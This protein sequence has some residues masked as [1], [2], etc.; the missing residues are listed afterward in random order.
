V[1]DEEDFR[2]A[3]ASILKR[4]GYQVDAV[5]DAES[6]LTWLESNRPDVVLTD[7]RLPGKSGLDVLRDA[8]AR[9]PRLPVLVVTAHGDDATLE[10]A[11]RLGAHRVLL[12]PVMREPL[13]D[14]LREALD[15]TQG[16]AKA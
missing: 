6:A 4:A 16:D 8:R 12:K 14:E 9:Y 5:G 1:D 10:Q 7:L 15:P 2:L 13:L 3:L 11:R